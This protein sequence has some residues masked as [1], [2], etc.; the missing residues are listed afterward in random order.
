MLSILRSGRVAVQGHATVEG[1]D[2]LKLV[3]TDGSTAIYVDPSTYRPIVWCAPD[4]SATFGVYEELPRGTSTEALLK[5]GRAATVGSRR[6]Q[7]RG[8][9]GGHRPPGRKALAAA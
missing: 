3:S 1:R 6:R 4:E 2:A 8:L 9:P 7:R 5:P